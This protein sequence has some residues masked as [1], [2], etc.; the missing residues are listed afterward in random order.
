MVQNLSSQFNQTRFLSGKTALVTGSTSGIGL[1]TARLLAEQGANIVLHGL[2][3]REEGNEMAAALANE[4]SVQTLFSDAN[5]ADA[6]QIDVLFTEINKAFSALDIVVNNAGIQH[7]ASVIEFPRQKWDAIIAINLSAAFHIM[8]H[9]LPM[10]Q[11]QG[12]GR[13]INIASVHGLVGSAN[14]SA[15]VAA[16]HGI[17]GLT[18]VSAI[19]EAANNITVNA[20][21]PG[22]VE[23]PLI[24]SQID[25]V[26]KQQN[27]DHQTAKEALI[28]RKQPLPEMAQPEQI[29]DFVL[30]LCSDAARSI[31]GASLTMDGAWTAQ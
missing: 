7:T 31:T 24:S 26:A 20:I 28:T 18:K 29:G 25:D 27:L 9:A 8:Q 6:E 5:L 16:K 3:G 14:K 15:Y 1:S 2:L 23:T 12:W 13:V 17:I 10:M 30:F 4:F 21:C 19:E 22:W 11:A